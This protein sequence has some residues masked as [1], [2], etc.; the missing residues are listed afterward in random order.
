MTLSWPVEFGLGIFA[1]ITGRDSS[2]KN[3]AEDCQGSLCHHRG[4]FCLKTKL[5]HCSAELR[6]VESWRQLLSTW[7]QPHLKLSAH[8]ICLIKPV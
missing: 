1:A 7:V 4:R 2:G 6:D 8:R 5:A 3:Y